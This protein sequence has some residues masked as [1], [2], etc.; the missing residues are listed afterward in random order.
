MD[1]QKKN[2]KR[3]LIVVGVIVLIGT[4]FLFLRACDTDEE[5]SGMSYDAE[6]EVSDDTPLAG[7]SNGKITFPGFSK[8][9]IKYGS[10][11]KMSLQ[12]PKSNKVDFVY[13]ISYNG[14]TVYTSEK[15]KPGE[16]IKW[17]LH[18]CFKEKGRY[19]VEITITPYSLQGEVKN[20]ILQAFTFEII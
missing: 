9:V 4:L 11:K 14:E 17:N 6:I 5:A 10:T 19:S 18:E 1:K 2:N 13:S 3:I 7:G 16:T 15:I 20:G 8:N 12:N